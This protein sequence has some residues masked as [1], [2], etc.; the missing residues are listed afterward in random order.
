MTAEAAVMNKHAVAL[1]ADSAVTAS[2]AGGPKIYNTVNKLFTLSKYAPVGMMI[3][4]NADFMA[5][6]WETIIKRFREK[7]GTDRCATLDEYATRF[8]HHLI[9]DMPFIA[10]ND[11]DQHVQGLVRAFYNDLIRKEIDRRVGDILKAA[12]VIEP[13]RV[14]EIAAE[15]IRNRCSELQQ[16]P[17]IPSIPNE[18]DA[19]FR[20][21]YRPQLDKVIE[22][23][24][25][26]L[27]LNPTAREGLVE[28]A[29]L[30]L[31]KQVL[32]PARSGVVI[33]GF[34]EDEVFPRLRNFEVDGVVCDFLRLAPRAEIDIT[35][36]RNA[37]IVPFAQ[38][39]VVMTFMEGLDPALMTLLK[40]MLKATLA[41]L[42]DA[43]LSSLPSGSFG[44]KQSARLRQGVAKMGEPMLQRIRQFVEDRHIKPII[45]AVGI[46][47]KDE[48]AAM[49]EALVNLT[50]FRRRVSTDTETVGGPIDVAVISKGDGFVWIKRK[51]YFRPELNPG[52]LA[53]Y[54]SRE[55]RE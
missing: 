29:M 10:D 54:Y 41:N 13:S 30:C 49:A 47:P 37:A 55:D 43:I 24:F 52:F 5:V 4:D 36:A 34:G 27:P 44:P 38:R 25:E 17:D 31:K 26:R 39:D 9:E 15:V 21:R 19:Q 2:L 51:H 7:L 20:E 35:V 28:I 23:Q 14:G 32:S 33:A 3:Y 40:E 12:P 45:S 1:A 46:L 53:N 6:P 8:R 16:A 22:A 48:L 42:P 18:F 11:K 50:S